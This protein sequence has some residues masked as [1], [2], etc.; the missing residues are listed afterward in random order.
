V[1]AWIAIL[2]IGVGTFL[3]RASFLFAYQ[4]IDLP[5]RA[6]RAL[7]LVPAAVLSAL[8]VPRFL[9]PEGAVAVVGNDRL[10]AGVVAAAV[11]WRTE[12]ILATILV[13]MA[14]LLGLGWLPELVSL[15]GAVSST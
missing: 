9:A 3:I 11:A 2:L 12:N 4:R 5:D 14:V 13:G 1:I 7:E 10:L 15:I 8:V 6:E